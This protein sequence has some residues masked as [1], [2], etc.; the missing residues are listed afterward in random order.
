MFA[1]N[2]KCVWAVVCCTTLVESVSRGTLCVCCHGCRGICVVLFTATTVVH[3]LLCLTVFTLPLSTLTVFAQCVD[4]DWRRWETEILEVKRASEEGK[5]HRYWN[6]GHFYPL[7][8][9]A[10]IV[11]ESIL[12]FIFF[13]YY[14]SSR[15][16]ETPK[17]EG[18]LIF[19][20]ENREGKCESLLL[21]F[22]CTLCQMEG[23]FLTL[24]FLQSL[25]QSSPSHLP[26]LS[27]SNCPPPPPAAVGVCFTLQP[28]QLDLAAAAAIQCH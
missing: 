21:R 9:L 26:S 23:T 22:R 4:K 25:P 11:F 13:F 5:Y 3:C 17:Q 14:C 1:D 19:G 8:H 7:L 18:V 15:L 16:V 10:L 20:F 28:V 24:S 27:S 6:T 12:F 2:N